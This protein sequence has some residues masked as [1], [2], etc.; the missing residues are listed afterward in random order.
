MKSRAIKKQ[1]ALDFN[2]LNAEA[3]K[4][5]LSGILNANFPKRTKPENSQIN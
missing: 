3:Q 5:L 1:L 4:T 2:S